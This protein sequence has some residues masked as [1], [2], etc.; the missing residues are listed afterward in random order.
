VTRNALDYVTLLPGVNT[1]DNSNRGS[2]IVGLPQSMINITIDGVNTQDN[3]NR[4]G[5]GFFTM[6]RASLD[7]I[8]E[9]T[10][11]TATPGAESAGQGAVQ[12]RFVTRSGNN[13]YHGSLYEYH[14][15][16][17]L[18][19]NSWFNNRN[20][21]APPGADPLTW[22]APP[23][24]LILNQ[25]GGRAGGPIAIPKLFK[26][27]DR[28]FFFVN[29]EESRQPNQATRNQ[30]VFSPEAEK[31]NFLY[32]SGGVT[33]SVNL[34]D[35]AAANGHVS[36]WDPT[37]Q[38]L[39][40]DIRTSTAQGSLRASSDPLYETLT[41]V[42]KGMYRNRFI[43]SRFDFNLTSKHRLEF[44]YSHHK[45]YLLRY[46]NTNNLSPAYPGFPNWG[47][48]G[49]NRFTG[50]VTLRSTLTPRIVNEV[51][52]GLS[53]GTVLFSPNMSNEMFTGPLANQGGFNLGI[54]AAGISSATRSSTGSRRN[55]PSDVIE[56]T[57]TWTRG[58]HGFSFGFSWTHVNAY[59]QSFR[60]VP[61]ISFGV[62]TT[63]DPARTMFATG[64]SNFPGASSSDLGD[65][66]SM[67]AVLTGRV[68]SIG[69]T[70][71]QNEKDGKY[72]YQGQTMQRGHMREMGGF[73]SDSWRLRSNLTLTLGVRWEF[74]FPFVPENNMYSTAS[75]ADVWGISG[76][77]NMFKPGTMTG[78]VPEFVQ[79]KSGTPGYNLSYKDLAPSFGFAWSPNMK[80]GWLG[81]ILGENGQTAIRGGYSLA[82]S[83]MGMATYMG[84]Y[85]GN[86]GSSL[87]ATRNVANG[88]LVSG[89]GS[90]VW[91][92]LFRE[93]SRLGPPAFPAA[94][95]YPIKLKPANPD[96]NSTYYV[97]TNST[98]VVAP[99]LRTPYAQSWTFGIQRELN[100]SMALEVRYVGTRS[101]QSWVTYNLN[102]TENNMLDNGTFE[103]FKLAMA[104]LQAN[105]SA[106][107]GN[108]F[109]YYGPNTG[110][111]PL[112]ITLGYFNGVPASQAGDP[113]K[114]TSSQFTTSGSFVNYLAKTNPNPSS[115]IGGLHS[116]PARRTNGATAGYAANFFLTNPDLRGGANLRGN[117]GYSRYDSMVI[118]LRRRMAKGLLVQAN[119]VW[120]K[121]FDRTRLSFR[122]PGV[123]DLGDTL[124]H[125]FK[126]NWVYELPIGR[127]RMLLADMH[128]WL[129]RIAGG[130]N[131][132][133][134]SRIQS[135]DWHDFGN[136][137]LIGM[138]YE[139]LRNAYQLRF[140]D[141]NRRIYVLPDD[142][143]QN[144][145][146]AFSTSATTATGYSGTV[147]SG[148][149]IAPAN[150][151][152][153][154]QVISGDCAPR[155]Y[156]I[157]GTPFVNFDLSLTK[158]VRFTETKNFELRG[159]FLNAF[160]NINFD[161]VS[162]PGS[163]QTWG[164]VSS[165]QSGGRIIQFVA[166]INF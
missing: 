125:A 63:Y 92:L 10:V 90:D 132:Q 119:Y 44:S 38:K 64:T 106:K 100:K 107:R 59:N 152:D 130:W 14:R 97:D 80:G 161:Y 120:A 27:K 55:A 121:S 50:S 115:Y 12:I 155:H 99:D 72:I 57:L 159:E 67:Y 35:L 126:V 51:R 30:T 81:R 7:A 116:D 18:N 71:Y 41:F 22:K 37:V 145:I 96:P 124:S 113:S 20:I 131:F 47:V 147:P 93:K 77:G 73:A 49:S 139:D 111:Y 153:C 75:L 76:V 5:D 17:A 129:D 53:A 28:A 143:I 65:A 89:V 135:G 70:A 164:Q 165:S 86:P 36:T 66:R 141:A 156:Y 15:N 54:D 24:W 144:T 83:R 158:Q 122:R 134:V 21:T 94:A 98:T 123:N 87:T 11:S 142:I 74:Q 150:T 40:A 33:R 60:T 151:A 19:A 102:S 8:E 16:S 101:L 2:T 56:D 160:N 140:D 58:T 104:N 136:V 13:E 78:K 108:N 29:I 154:I 109:K 82:Y 85:S 149:Y 110:T 133:G 34:F 42:N 43:T 4:T 26:G 114:Y 25:F 3:Y 68:T 103:E 1:T 62:D 112:P 23:A 157:R 127:G 117:G 6:V 84:M 46:D 118:E 69:G 45:Y 166:R 79:Y 91:P 146:N 32:V 162:N 9:V 61:S 137:R 148:R 52:A 39:L 31:G 88:N 163:S 48:Q 95:S 138:T 128:P 105:I